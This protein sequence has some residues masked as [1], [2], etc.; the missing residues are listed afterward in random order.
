[1][2]NQSYAVEEKR[3]EAFVK[4]TF[5][6]CP[7]TID[8]QCRSNA[9]L[10]SITVYMSHESAVT[11]TE[12]SFAWPE[13][14]C[15]AASQVIAV[16][17]C[18]VTPDAQERIETVGRPDIHLTEDGVLT[19]V[20][21][22]LTWLRARTEGRRSVIMLMGGPTGGANL[23]SEG[24][25]M[26][27]ALRD[28]FPDIP[29]SDIVFEPGSKGSSYDTDENADRCMNF[30]TLLGRGKEITPFV[31]LTVVTRR[32]H[33]RR[34]G[35]RFAAAI[36]RRKYDLRE[37]G[38]IPYVQVVSD[39]DVIRDNM[40]VELAMRQHRLL[41][42]EINMYER[43]QRRN[44]RMEAILRAFSRLPYGARVLSL[45]ARAQRHGL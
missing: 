22:G 10:N 15:P 2:L 29:G 31:G 7:S 9:K 44:N 19:V 34:A 27:V 30:L 1:M 8:R 20:A 16:L 23:P 26:Y 11:A 6:E 32:F 12:S 14:E 18:G 5:H 42:G 24:E 33:G 41:G 13:G 40:A 17:G 35:E 25:A 21:A 37:V 28:L 3:R 39:V 38:I 36:N 4:H 43:R 45:I